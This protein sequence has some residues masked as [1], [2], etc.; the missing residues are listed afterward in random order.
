MSKPHFV[1]VH[2][3]FHRAWHLQS[4]VER[5]E[6]AGYPVSTL[7]LP[8]VNQ[9]IAKVPRE[10]GLRADVDAV[11]AVIEEA[12]LNSAQIIL[13]FHSYGGVPGG[14]AAAELSEAAKEKVQ[15]LVYMCAFVIE[16]GTAVTTASKGQVAPWAALEASG[17]QNW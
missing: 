1:L 11:K 13:V 4:L 14:E 17:Y 8:S 16:Q 7:D 15:R 10:G 5:L 2:G 6:K 12:A 3:A 9:D